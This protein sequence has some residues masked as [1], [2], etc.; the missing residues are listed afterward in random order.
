[1]NKGFVSSRIKKR[2]GSRNILLI[3][4]VVFIVGLAYSIVTNSGR[5][6]SAETVKFGARKAKIQ[7]LDPDVIEQLKKSRQIS[8]KYEIAG[9]GADTKLNSRMHG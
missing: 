8:V 5:P 2:H 4:L 1:M 9:A 6:K 7:M 3:I